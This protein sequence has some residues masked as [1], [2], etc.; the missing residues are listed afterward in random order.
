MINLIVTKQQL[1]EVLS[2]DQ[3]MSM[4]MSLSRLC[5]PVRMRG[6]RTV[7]LL[8]KKKLMRS[9]YFLGIISPIPPHFRALLTILIENGN[10]RP[11]QKIAYTI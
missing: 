2:L 7:N 11:T 1:G 8:Y 5:Q 9:L 4:P 6:S 3:W 10:V